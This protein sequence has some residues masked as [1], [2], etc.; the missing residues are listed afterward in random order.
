MPIV[1]ERLKTLEPTSNQLILL[2]RERVG[3]GGY[4]LSALRNLK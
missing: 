1:T 4:T 3:G 2:E